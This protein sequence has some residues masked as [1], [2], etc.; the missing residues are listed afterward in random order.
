M[1]HRT[2][3][4]F[5]TMAFLMIAMVATPALAH[6]PAAS[7]GNVK[8]EML[9]WIK[10]A[11][12]K[13]IQLAEATPDAKYGWKPGKDVRTTG[14]VF[15]H[16]TAANYGVPSFWGVAPP[17]GFKFDTFE[18]SLTKKADIQAALKASFA[19]MEKG[20]EAMSDADLEKS[21]EFFGMKSTVRGGY[22]LLLSHAHEHLGQSIAYARMN[23]I[24]PPWTIAQQ[25]AIKAMAEKQKAA[26]GK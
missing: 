9:A 15:M 19:H 18:K 21:V 2:R 20:F 24:V 17:A 5:A 13:L 10:D 16:V 23:G 25:E 1:T 6:E 7:A 26:G 12:D 3:F 11:E 22:M 14:E 8:S 4:T